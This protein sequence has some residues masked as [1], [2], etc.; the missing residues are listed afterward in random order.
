MRLYLSRIIL[1][2][3]A[4]IA[5]ISILS[6]FVL[7]LPLGGVPKRLDVITALVP[8]DLVFAICIIFAG[9]GYEEQMP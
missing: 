4:L 9:K 3:I 8:L 2:I 5:N 6:V 7:H 1:G